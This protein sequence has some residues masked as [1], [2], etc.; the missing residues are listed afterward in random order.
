MVTGEKNIDYGYYQ[1]R[2]RRKNDPEEEVQR[3]WHN[4]KNDT[5]GLFEHV[6]WGGD[7]FVT[8]DKGILNKRDK[9]ASIVP[10]K[11]F[12]PQETLEELSKMELPLLQKPPWHFRLEVQHCEICR[13]R[14][15]MV[16]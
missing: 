13:I 14:Q 1:Y 15:Q 11:I 16:S 12:T 9:L 2:E 8:S 3:K 5:L 6:K 4:Q 7:I 10:G